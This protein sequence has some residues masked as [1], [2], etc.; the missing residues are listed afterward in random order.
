MNIEA[1]HSKNG[2][3]YWVES[4]DTLY[5]ARLKAGQYQQRNWEFAQ[6]VI[7]QYRRVIDIGSNN[8]CNAIHYAEKFNQ[9]ECY[10]PVVLAQQLW[11]N[12]VRDN[13][14]SNVVLHTQALGEYNGNTEIIIHKLNGGHNH[15]LHMDKNPRARGP[16]TRTT[17]AV[18]IRTLDSYGFTEVDFIKVDVEGYEYFVLQGAVNTI[19]A[20][21]PLIQ[22]EIVANQCRKFN[23]KAE[24]LINW[25]R[26]MNYRMCSKIEGWIDG[27]ITSKGRCLYHN[28]VIRQG[29]MDLFFIP[30]EWNTQLSTNNF[31][32]LFA[33]EQ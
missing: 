10:E 30:V 12:T 22:L 28:G 8:A 20:N 27:E 33:E 3:T 17:E 15:L 1:I 32:E 4:G 24:T 2:K 26:S 11:H 13:Q 25:L 6:K 14:V 21:R 31:Q 23:Y 9:V 19:A 5:K 29:D 7:P 16:I 18:A